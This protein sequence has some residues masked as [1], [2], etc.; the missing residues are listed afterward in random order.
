M[1]EYEVAELAISNEALYWQVA[2]IAQGSLAQIGE[3]L[4]RFMSIL[5]G[6]L[7]VAF[8]VGA[9]LTRV[10]AGIFTLL[11]LFW[12]VRLSMTVNIIGSSLFNTLDKMREMNPDMPIPAS[13]FT[14]L[15]ILL[16]FV[17]AASLYFMWNIR[18]PRTE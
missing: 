12:L 13:S 9:Q 7:I 18:H 6:Y 14:G 8:F 3:I 4:G 11:Y 17:T 16:L 1:T 2:E 10:Q 5:F 15:Y